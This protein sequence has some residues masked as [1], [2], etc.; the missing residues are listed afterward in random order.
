MLLID[1]TTG[2]IDTLRRNFVG[3]TSS[4]SVLA[5]LGILAVTPIIIF[6]LIK[7]RSRRQNS[8]Q[9]DINVLGNPDVASNN[10]SKDEANDNETSDFEDDADKKQ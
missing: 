5:V 8:V 6:L 2:F 9:Q 1:S 4:L 7:Y 3:A 10:D